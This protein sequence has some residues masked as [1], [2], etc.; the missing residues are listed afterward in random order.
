VENTCFSSSDS[1][2]IDNPIVATIATIISTL[3]EVSVVH[4]TRQKEGPTILGGSC[5]YDPEGL[6]MVKWLVDLATH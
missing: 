5:T 1:G 3:E 6:M 4:Q 2:N